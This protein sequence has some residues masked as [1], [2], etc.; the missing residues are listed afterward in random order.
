MNYGS[1]RF[2]FRHR[3]WKRKEIIVVPRVAAAD[4]RK[5]WYIRSGRGRRRG[6]VGLPVK[7]RLGIQFSI[8][9]LIVIT[10]DREGRFLRIRVIW[11]EEIQL[12]LNHHH[13]EVGWPT[14]KKLLPLK[15]RVLLI[16]FIKRHTIF[17]LAYL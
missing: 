15:V 11:K 14:V 13:I 3:N 10:F 2:D 17:V 12:F 5:D 16:I 6:A 4:N 1:R 7:N 9:C 8:H